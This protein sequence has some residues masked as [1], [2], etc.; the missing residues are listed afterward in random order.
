MLAV[1]VE[2]NIMPRP[3][4][5]VLPM[6]LSSTD[7]SSEQRV[8]AA[9]DILA[10]HTSTGAPVEDLAFNSCTVVAYALHTRRWPLARR[11]LQWAIEAGQM[12]QPR[13]KG[14]NVLV[15]RTCAP[16]H[17]NRKCYRTSCQACMAWSV[18]PGNCANRK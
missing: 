15:V 6:L 13:W 14:I 12:T 1:E 2:N 10:S 18:S 3:Q 8:L 9:C 17:L 11:I 7:A 5:P 4:F 16:A